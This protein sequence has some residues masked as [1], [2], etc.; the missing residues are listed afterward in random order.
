M[1]IMCR[2]KSCSL[3]CLVSASAFASGS[4]ATLADCAGIAENSQRLACYD[5]LATSDDR[6][7]G[8]P[9]HKVQTQPAPE[10]AIAAQ[11]TDYVAQQEFSLGRH[12]EIGQE[13]KRGTFDFRPHR[14]NY[15]LATYSTSPN[16][17]PY[18]PFRQL[19]P[20]TENLSHAEITFQLGFKMKGMENILNSNSDLWFAYTQQSFW[21]ANNQEASSPFRETNYQPELMLVMPLNF[22]ILGMKARFANFGYIHQSNG[23]TSTLSRSWNRLYAQAGLEKDNFT[24]LARIWKRIGEDAADDDNPDIIDYMGHGDLLGTYYVNGHEFSL[25]ARNNFHTHRGAVQAGWAFPLANQVKG[26]VQI[27]SGYGQS[28]IDYNY[29]QKTI[30]LGVVVSY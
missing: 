2:M 28:L 26:Y 15:L 3:L 16:D 11:Q 18:R 12:W 8:A 4:P 27:F 1:K 5:R 17:A 24:L 22:Q 20:E 13:N 14:P 9:A 6:N 21:Q 19:V 29:S 25:L 7:S 10:I 23:Q 30:G